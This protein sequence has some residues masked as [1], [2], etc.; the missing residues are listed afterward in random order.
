[1]KKLVL[2]LSIVSLSPIKNKQ[3]CDIKGNVKNPGVYEIKENYTIQNV[4]NDAGGLKD[5]SYTNNINLS[6]KVTDEM[7]IYIHSKTE[8]NKIKE[9][10]NCICEPK[11]TECKE[12]SIIDENKSLNNASNE[13]NTTTKIITETTTKKTT[14]KLVTTKE[15]TTKKTT[16]TKTPTTT[17]T[18]TTKQIIFPINI[19]TCTY[20]DLL[21][22]KGLGEKK[23]EKI[24]QYRNEFGLYKSIEEIKNISGI[25]NTLFDAIKE[26]IT[27]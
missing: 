23:A 2:F 13:T 8:I 1:M 17:Q 10:Q 9:L 25:G 21:N 18:T 11:I 19:N 27:V 7:V 5:N 14:S 22:I 16:T 4:I 20:E 24:I 6:K 26:Y 12:Q 15:P 3:Y